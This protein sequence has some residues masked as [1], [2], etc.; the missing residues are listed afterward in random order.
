MFADS[1]SNLKEE[2]EKLKAIILAQSE[3]ISYYE[4]DCERSE[5]TDDEIPEELL[6]AELQLY[7][8]EEAYEQW[9]KN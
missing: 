9:Q 4:F 8:A 3:V 7:A 5:Y 1:I 6:E 2:V